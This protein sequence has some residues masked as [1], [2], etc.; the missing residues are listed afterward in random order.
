MNSEYFDI[1]DENNKP[2]GEKRLRSEVHT[3]GLW[4]RTVHIYFYRNIGNSTQF[5][6]HLRSKTK[7][8]NPDKWDTRFGGHLKSGESLEDA[9][10]NEVRE[11]TGIEL[12]SREL[13]SGETYKRDYFPNREFTHV[14]YYHYQREADTL[15]FD[16]GEVQTAK[17]MSVNDIRA[18][19]QKNPKQWSADFKGLEEVVSFLAK[20]IAR[21]R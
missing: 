16:D 1:I 17:W 19:I 11:E 21:A 20:T 3:L 5:L 13:L 7:D 18:S 4:H 15:R 9:V 10:K 6:V 12:D 2:I 14:Y 8:L